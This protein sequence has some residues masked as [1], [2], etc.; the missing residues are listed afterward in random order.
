MDKPIRVSCDIFVVKNT[1]LLLGVRKG[2]FG[3]G[4]WGLPGGHLEWGERLLEAAK[5]EL[6]EETSLNPQ[7]LAFYTFSDEPRTDEHYIHFAFITKKFTR[8][9]QVMEPERCEKWQFFDL[10][11][12]P[13]NLFNPHR[14]LI[15][16]L[17][18]KTVY[19]P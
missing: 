6:L 15:E 2:K 11:E 7:D 4:Q 1:Q 18:S 17:K 10:N 19:Q 9:P 5:R 3:A 16:N 13:D 12:L 14:Q 8:K